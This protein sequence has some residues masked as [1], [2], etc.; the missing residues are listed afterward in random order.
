MQAAHVKKALKYAVLPEILPRIRSFVASG[1]G[2]LAYMV[3]VI[4]SMARLLP[5]THPYCN[6]QNIGRFGI[7]H[8]IVEAA[9]HLVISRRNIDQIAIFGAV[10]TGI[11]LLA[12]QVVLLIYGLLVKPAQAQ[13]SSYF[14][15][16]IFNTPDQVMTN[17][18][19]L[20]M[21]DR[22][23]G[24]P[25]M[26][27]NANGACTKINAELPWAMH[28]GLHSLFEFYSYAMLL[29]GVMIFLYFVV[30]VVTET[31]V[32][33]HPFGQRFQNVWVPIRLVV[34]LGL[35]VPINHGYNSGQYLALYSAKM[36]S[37]IAT[38][39]WL[40]FNQ[41]ISS[42]LGEDVNPTG[43]RKQ[44]MVGIP[45]PQSP[46]GLV[47]AMSLIH[48]CAYGEWLV[49]Q[50]D[51]KG[52]SDY[53]QAKIKPYFVKN[54]QPNGNSEKYQEVSAGTDYKQGLA[55]YNGGDIIIRF[56]KH[57][58]AIYKDETGNV[59][60]TCGEIRVPVS[61]SYNAASGS[62]VGP[63]KVLGRYFKTVL[64]MWF[65]GHSNGSMALRAGAIRFNEVA[66]LQPDGREA[67]ACGAT[68]PGLENGAPACHKNPPGAAWKDEIVAHYRGVIDP[69]VLR[70]WG[71][72]VAYKNDYQMNADML[73]LGWGGAA[74]WYNKIAQVNGAFMG[75]VMNMPV[76]NEYPVMMK[77][78]MALK[79]EHDSAPGNE[80]IF[81]PN[82]SQENKNGGITGGKLLGNP[83]NGKAMALGRA[84]GI[85]VTDGADQTSGEKQV[86]GNF[87][88]D[89]MS[90]VLGVEGIYE[91]RGKNAHIHPLAQLSM[92]GKGMVEHTIR[93]MAIANTTA[94]MGGLMA[95][96]EKTKGIG[97]L[98]NAV[99]G[100]FST[101]A[102][103]GMTAGV[104]LYYVLPFLPF[105]YFFFAMGAW[106]KSVFEAMVG[107]PLWALA[108]LRLDGEGLA[109]ESASSGYFLILE[110]GLRPILIVFG[111]IAAILIFTAQVRVLNYIWD[112]VTANAAGFSDV[113][114]I[115]TDNDR[116]FKRDVVEQFGH[117][118]IY[119][120]IVYML[121]N[122]S[123]KLID[124][125]PNEAVRWLGSGAASYAK[126]EQNTAGQL[127][128]YVSTAGFVQGQQLAGQL[129]KLSGGLGDMT[130]KAMGLGGKTTP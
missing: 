24:I 104:T 30:V 101:T 46:A 120:V 42:R 119:T 129:Q 127:S 113:G 110:I 38:N 96:S 37:G 28:S 85:W 115:A 89:A 78:V 80:N 36:G 55:F 18:V 41:S 92:V 97:N 58:P 7:R 19:A 60:P 44:A 16:S 54:V 75:V 77:R 47:Q 100:I 106:V 52:G 67:R 122:S 65:D 72:Y 88:R 123:F 21:L 108:H 68:A 94:F 91:I 45:Q 84:Y 116:T 102:F 95:V 34:A 64:D 86:V 74:I 51:Q 90:I 50:R 5:A 17:D 59:E 43:E 76:M 27:C 126:Q 124:L 117:T 3:A 4:F 73:H 87:F 12:M 62:E 9:N 14:G 109:G 105:I 61:I 39:G 40:R 125:I 35:L 79:Q 11:F 112:F 33:G 118:V 83:D 2:P 82:F 57:D 26:F 69:E 20:G 6:P 130:G 53:Q 71:E 98:V 93:N 81:I 1:F 13:L 29:V 56:G 10:L 23:F 111:L 49:D 128:N 121:A 103:L 15:E 31:A 48:T 70:I 22:V 25:G 66:N 8:A 63:P 107:I 99:G 32:S 114:M